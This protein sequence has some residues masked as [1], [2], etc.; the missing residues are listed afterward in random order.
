MKISNIILL[1]LFGSI[2]MII[3][4]GALQL[5]FTGT[6]KAHFWEET[7]EVL[8]LQPFRHLVIKKAWNINIQ[9]SEEL[10]L[11]ISGA[12]DQE[13]PRIY[14][15]QNGDTLFIDSIGLRPE[16]RTFG[17]TINTPTEDLQEVHA[18]GSYFSIADFHGDSLKI[19]LDKSNLN[20]RSVKNERIGSLDLIGV[21]QSS[22]GTHKVQFD[23]VKLSLDNSSARFGHITELKGTISNK[24]TVH[25]Q[26]VNLIE[27]KMD[28]T[29]RWLN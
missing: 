24:A 6:E 12:K 17:L 27:L 26:R 14:F 29:S 25:T 9:S 7:S 5:R 19:T 20:L 18:L 11:I 13:K 10:K 28:S 2:S 21:N 22:I 15:H 3:I 4:A 8:D 23:A 1:S 16:H